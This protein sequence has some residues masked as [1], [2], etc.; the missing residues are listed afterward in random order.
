MWW[1]VLLVLRCCGVWL[2]VTKVVVGCVDGPPDHKPHGKGGKYAGDDSDPET[3]SWSN[4]FFIWA[5]LTSVRL[6]L[7]SSLTCELTEAQG[8]R[9]QCQR[10]H[11]KEG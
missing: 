8:P 9:C 2:V 4:R 10:Q 5:I 6:A 7:S 3:R 1:R 11:V